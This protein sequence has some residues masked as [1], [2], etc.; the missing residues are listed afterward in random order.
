M[1]TISIKEPL[2]AGWE[3]FKAN[4]STFVAFGLVAIGI[5]FAEQIGLGI[6]RATGPLKPAFLALV[7]V[8]AR[9]AQ[10][11]LQLVFIHAALKVVDGQK[12]STGELSRPAPDFLGFLLASV[13][14][15]LV[16]CAGLMLLVVPGIIWAVRYGAYGYALVNEHLDPVEALKRSAKLTEGVRWELF[17]FGLALIGVNI[18]GA[19]A[20][21]VGLVATVPVTAIAAARVYRQLVA[22]AATK[23]PGAAFTPGRP[24]EAH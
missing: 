22:R 15:G 9:V 8:A 3:G 18:I 24:I 11:W 7:S 6:A 4:L 20:L 14:Y 17:V 12:I 10:I 1:R 19:M 16:V 23:E 5:W 2:A 13:L 21:G